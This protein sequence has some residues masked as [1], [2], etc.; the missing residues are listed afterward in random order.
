MKKVVNYRPLFFIF[1]FLLCGIVMARKVF[2]KDF[3]VIS[4]LVLTIIAMVI[5]L[6]VAKKFKILCLLLGVF[7]LGGGLF[8]AGKA[9]YK[10]NEYT[11]QVAV[12]GRV[13]DSIKEGEHYYRVILD[14]VVIEGKSDK[15]ISLYI[16][17][18]AGKTVKAGDK[19]AF[20][21]SLE[22]VSLWTLK[23]FNSYYYRNNI[24]YVTSINSSSLVVVDGGLKLDESIRQ[25]VKKRLEDNLSK[26][27]AG[28]CYALLFG[29]KIEISND[30]LLNYK[31]AG[32]IHILAV[33]G[34]HV[35]FL[36][37]LLLGLMKLC[38]VNKYVSFVL[39]T[40][41]I[42]FFAYLCSFTPSV[43]RAGLMGIFFMLSRLLGRRYDTLSSLGLAG[44]I[45][46][47]VSPLTA[48]DIGFLMSVFCVL[49]ISMLSKLFTKVFVKAMPYSVAA[50]LS[51]S[52]SSQIITLPF[53]AYFGGKF[54]FLSPFVNLIIVPFFGILFPYLVVA[55][56]VSAILPFMG[57]ILAP[58]GWGFSAVTSVVRFFGNTSLYLP[59]EKV[60]VTVMIMFFVLI[61]VFS[62]FVLLP[63]NKKSAVI[64]T[65]AILLSICGLLSPLTIKSDLQSA[66][67]LCSSSSPCYVLTSS[68]GE[69]MLVGYNSLVENYAREYNARKFDYFLSFE[70]INEEDTLAL[71]SFGT[72]LFVACS[73]DNSCE[74]TMYSSAGECGEFEYEF[75]KSENKIL[76]VGIQFDETKIF[77]A[78]GASTRYNQKYE[79]YFDGFKPS[80]IFV[81]ENDEIGHDYVTISLNKNG[82]S[83]TSFE[84]NG[85]MK[86]TFENIFVYKEALD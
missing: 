50:A 19:I 56:F 83:W 72:G 1:V 15:N 59:I 11:G 53:T 58:A 38:K 46:L 65:L 2:D 55:S 32:I 26:E 49:G 18:R 30:T 85:N 22:S 4:F 82:Q 12:V 28:L 70:P 79:E 8:F 16:S 84:E 71:A 76:G 29:D 80:V 45:I 3:L 48:F 66:V 81:G 34:L 9:C 62:K 86:F 78:T 68:S 35:S 37:A 6:C 57:F 44:S 61:F 7:I 69:R 27:N 33:S 24:G 21:S 63:F 10:V 67:Q 14:D 20:E 51:V 5:W 64:G 39:T 25:T 42:I 73:G 47:L 43:V 60:H 52:L 13:T 23:N 41:F 54:N 17:V 75:L 40:A 77:I 31:N 36:L 74:N